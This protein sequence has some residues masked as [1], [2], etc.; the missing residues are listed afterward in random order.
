MGEHVDVATRLFL[1]TDQTH[2][3]VKFSGFVLQ[4][5]LAGLYG[6]EVRDDVDLEGWREGC[7]EGFGVWSLKFGECR[8]VFCLFVGV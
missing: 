1:S 6:E 7:W 2:L 3:T 8:V 5:K 4:E